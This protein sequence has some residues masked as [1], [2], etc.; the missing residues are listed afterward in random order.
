MGLTLREGNREYFYTKLDEIFPGLAD[1]Y[2]SIYKDRYNVVSPRNKR[3]MKFFNE[4]TERYSIMNDNEK[5]FS[6]LRE[7]E[8]KKEEKQL[9][10][11]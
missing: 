4:Y 1:E 2:I 5:I 10:L 8:D 9:Y 6:Y 3:L 7:F 11:F